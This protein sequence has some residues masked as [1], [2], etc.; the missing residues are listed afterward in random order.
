MKKRVLITVLLALLL[1]AVLFGVSL[2]RTAGNMLD[3]EN[4]GHAYRNFFI[5]VESYTQQTSAFPTSLDD[6]LSIEVDLGYEGVR[7]P[8]DADRIADLIQPDFSII[9]SSDNLSMFAPNYESKA[10]WAASDCA[11]YWER[12]LDN[13]NAND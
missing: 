1:A 2:W 4:R 10:D 6:L 11:F 12:I 3:A 9:P 13:L 8:E 5:V 7:W